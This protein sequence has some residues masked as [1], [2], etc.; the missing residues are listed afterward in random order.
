MTSEDL[1][2]VLLRFED[3]ARLLVV[4]QVSAGRKNRSGSR[5]TAP[6]ALQWDAEAEQLWLGHRERPNE[7]H[8]R[9]SGPGSDYPS[10]HP[11]GF[12]DTFKQLYRAVYRAVEQAACRT[13]RTF[14]RSA[15]AT[16]RSSSARRS[17]RAPRRPLGRRAAVTRCSESRRRRR[18]GNGTRRAAEPDVR[19]TSCSRS[20]ARA[21]AVPTCTSGTTSSRPRPV[22]MGHEVSAVVR[23][24]VTASTGGL[25]GTG[26]SAR[27]TSR[28]AGDASGVSRAGRTSASSAARSARAR[29]GRSRRCCSCRR[30]TS[31][32]SRTGSTVTRP[33]RRAAR[34]RLQLP[35]RPA[36]RPRGRPGARRRPR[37]GRPARRAGRPRRRRRRPRRRG[38][39]R[40]SAREARELG[41]ETSTSSPTT[42]VVHGEFDVAI[43]CSGSA[44]GSRSRSSP[45]RAADASSRSASPA[46]RS[47]S[48]STSSATAS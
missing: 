3:G 48:P 41:F 34:V 27:R 12:P 26:W 10:G 5:P 19:P 38:R 2:H 17:R 13:S 39:R 6:R 15:T 36:G 40:G 7:V 14:R 16:T 45:P 46:S 24:S 23:S 20:S 30:T 37:P 18:A 29:T 32:G 28:P 47:R 1:A 33:P 42:T 31:I 44:P 35:P 8:W 4:S 22:T 21:S 43:E 11:E 25:P 9:E